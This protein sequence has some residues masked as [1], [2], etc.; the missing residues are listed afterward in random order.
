MAQ[1]GGMS[2]SEL[3]QHNVQPIINQLALY[4]SR[5]K[6]AVEWGLNMLQ[7]NTQALG[8]GRQVTEIGGLI[9]QLHN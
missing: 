1:V 2:L 6:P 9:S 3:M 4:L 5:D 8:K 7:A